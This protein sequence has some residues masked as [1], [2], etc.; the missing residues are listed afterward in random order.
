MTDL[1][2]ASQMWRHANCPGNRILIRSLRHHG[3]LIEERVSEDA[4]IGQ[5]IHAALEGDAD[6]KLTFTEDEIKHDCD[7]LAYLCAKRFA[8]ESTVN[9]ERREVRYDYWLV[10]KPELK[11]FTG[12]PDYVQ[13]LDG[14]R[15]IM[16]INYKTGRKESIESHL[17]LQLRT[18]VVL[19]WRN[20]RPNEIG[21]AIVEPLV[22]KQPT[23][24]VYNEKELIKAEAEILKIVEKTDSDSTRNAGAWC[25][26]C[27]AKAFCAEAKTLALTNPVTVET[28]DQMPVGEHGAQ[29]LERIH[30]AMKLLQTYL[31]YYKMLVEENFNVIPG[32]H[33]SQGKEVRSIDAGAAV[34]AEPEAAELVKTTMQVTKL[35]EM[36]KKKWGLS[37]KAFRTKFAT[38][39][40]DAISTHTTK[41]SLQKIPKDLLK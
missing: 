28:I 26:H 27:P 29:T 24:V 41:G 17:N 1:P 13:F 39:F 35:E 34:L 30:I 31:D 12:K 4:T 14:N 33:I 5:R 40:R 3:I 8:G 16:N 7:R 6:L 32:W 36:M 18:E 15:R 23:I 21:A 38:T 25:L 37:G 19:I 2:S 11:F 10:Q 9:M 22:S 20:Y